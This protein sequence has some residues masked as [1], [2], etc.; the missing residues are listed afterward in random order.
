MRT[1]PVSSSVI[2]AQA[3]I[4]LSKT[5]VAVEWQIGGRIIEGSSKGCSTGQIF[6]GSS[7]GPEMK[8]TTASSPGED[9]AIASDSLTT[10]VMTQRGWVKVSSSRHLSP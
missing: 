9:S 8:D 3:P 6:S 7:E 4:E 5:S 10:S 2:Q 1:A